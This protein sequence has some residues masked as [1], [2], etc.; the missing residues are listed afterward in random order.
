MGTSSGGRGEGNQ[1]KVDIKHQKGL[2]PEHLDWPKAK[3][4]KQ[5]KPETPKGIKLPRSEITAQR[6]KKR[7]KPRPIRVRPNLKHH[8]LAL[9]LRPMQI[10]C[11]RR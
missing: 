2:S 10:S 8:N 6:N 7:A 1:P 5:A 9:A 4:L 11:R 3:H